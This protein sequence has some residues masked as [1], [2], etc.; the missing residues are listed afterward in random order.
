[1]PALCLYGSYVLILK[2][3]PDEELGWAMDFWVSRDKETLL[4]VD[5][6]EESGE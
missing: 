6:K 3:Q 5:A 4:H 2:F 1:V